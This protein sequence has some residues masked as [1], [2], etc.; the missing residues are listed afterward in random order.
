MTEFIGN[1]FMKETPEPLTPSQIIDRAEKK[2]FDPMIA[3][4]STLVPDIQTL[5]VF[6]HS[7]DTEASDKNRIVEIFKQI[8]TNPKKFHPNVI[9][10]AQKALGEIK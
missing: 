10:A 3:Q 9:Q 1:N 4:D 2:L 7:A 6:Y 8:I 5:T